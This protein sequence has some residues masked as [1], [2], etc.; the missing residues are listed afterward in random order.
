[1]QLNLKGFCAIGTLSIGIFSITGCGVSNAKPSSASTTTQLTGSSGS[2]NGSAP[3]SPAGAIIISSIQNQK[4]WQT[5]GG[6]GNEGGTGPGPVYD[7]TQGL[8]SP[9]LSGSSADFW[10]TGGPAYSGGYYFIEQPTV[11]N[12]VSYLRYEFDLYIPAQYASAPQALEFECQQNANGYTYNYAWQADYASKTWRV[13]NYTTKHWEATSVAFQPFAPDTWHH[14][15]AMY[16]ASGTQVIHDSITVDGVT[17]PVNITHSALFTGNGLE[18]TNA[19]QVDLD[20]S[21]SPYHVYVDN[22]TV[23]LKD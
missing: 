17:Y 5:C 6:C 1:M 15:I 9:A 7:V 18:L 23:S 13:F 14:I 20:G 16:H 21:S 4:G 10:I 22:M 3:A 19:F 2:N 11:P 8:A 12:P